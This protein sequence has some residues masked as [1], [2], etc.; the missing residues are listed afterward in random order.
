MKNWFIK[1]YGSHIEL[2]ERLLRIILSAGFVACIIGLLIS[3]ALKQPPLLIITL[4]AGG[5]VVMFSLW[6]ICR[7]RKLEAATWLIEILVNFLLFPIAFFTSGGVHGGATIWY[8]LGILFIFLLFRGKAFWGFLFATLTC[9]LATY[10]LAHLYPEGLTYFET[11]REVFIDSAFAMVVVSLVGGALMKFQNRVFEEE[12]KKV[13]AQQEELRQLAASKDVFFANV[14]HEIRTPINTILGLNEM[15][16]REEISDEV[17]ENAMNI[18]QASK[19]LLALVNDILDMS[20]IESGRMEIIPVQYE[21]G[22]LFSDLVNIIWVRAHEKNLELKI[23]IAPEMPSMLY[24][25][26]IRL[27]QVIL[28]LLSNAVKYTQEGSITLEAKCE[29]IDSDT[30]CLRI[31]VEDTG[32]GIRKEELQEVFHAFR[33]AD[34]EKNRVVEG[35]GLGLKISRQL[36]ELMGGSITVDSTYH[37]GSVFTITV[38]QKIVNPEPLGN[39]DFL[40]KK[41]LMTREHYHQRFEAEE[42]RVLVVDDNE[43]N[44]LVATKLLRGTKVQVDVAK[45]GAEALV[46]TMNKYYHAIFMDH[47]MPD[48]DGEQTMKRIRNQKNG[49]CGEVPIVV[50]T[51][52]A[53][54]GA[55]ETYRRLGFDGYL[56]KPINAALL[57]ATLLRYIPSDLVTFRDEETEEE[58]KLYQQTRKK[59]KVMITTERPADLRKEWQEELGIRVQTCYINTENGRFSDVDEIAAESVLAYLQTGKS[60]LSEPASVEDFENFFASA[61]ASAE[62]VI[63]ISV[64]SGV[65]KA[66]ENAC[67]AARCFDSVHVI[68]SGHV[69][70]SMGM[71]AMYAARMAMEGKTAEE[72]LAR[73]DN[74]RERLNTSFVVGSTDA[75][76]VN[77]RVS[78]RINKLCNTLDLSLILRVH[79]GVMRCAA[80]HFGNE[81]R[82]IKNY[83]RSQLRNKKRIDTRMLCIAHAGCSKK[84]QEFI[85]REVEKYVKFERVMV[86]KVSATIASN[87][88]VGSFGL[89]FYRKN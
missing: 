52:N 50:L 2:R 74:I 48:M 43:M 67:E 75:M 22:A 64:S 31:S 78:E 88:G 73:M 35:T 3:S 16:L 60:V 49:L 55:E 46:M 12:R 25:D 89:L 65:A 62:Q 63:H 54:S 45:S 17:A 18:Q 27:K 1:M 68:D 13:L 37:Q 38:E 69:S 59:K 11:T 66:Y 9:F 57:E 70:C 15:I 71:M 44:L 20:K 24:G 7:W 34:R 14:S 79:R 33:R 41:K 4:F 81:N 87:C 23:D 6:L 28:N 72:I 8:V 32:I 26:E 29:Q 77:G 83:I 19:M 47:V 85:V 61:L 5:V 36:L 30:V 21:T 84:K 40:V 53:M 51:A 39:I 42:G 76:Y 80:I 10:Q 56:A 86:Q 82:V 58:T